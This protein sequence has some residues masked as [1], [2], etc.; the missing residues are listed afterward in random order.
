MSNRLEG[1]GLGGGNLGGWR[2]RGPYIRGRVNN[3]WAAGILWGKRE[4]GIIL[5]SELLADV[6]G[7]PASAFIEEEQRDDLDK[8]A[9][10]GNDHDDHYEYDHDDG[11]WNTFDDYLAHGF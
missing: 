9:V 8:A 6:A 3:Y 4:G 5:V 1:E 7:P 10:G 2:G 11:V